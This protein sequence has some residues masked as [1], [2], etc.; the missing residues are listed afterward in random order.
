[1][2]CQ[3]LKMETKQLGDVQLHHLIVTALTVVHGGLDVAIGMVKCA[4]QN[5]KVTF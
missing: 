5:I 1:M 2:I 4:S 3:A